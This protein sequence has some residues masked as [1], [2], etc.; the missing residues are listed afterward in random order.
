MK[1]ISP[2]AAPTTSSNLSPKY[3]M[4]KN[5]KFRKMGLIV[6]LL[7]RPKG[8]LINHK[9][10]ETYKNHRRSEMCVLLPEVKKS[11]LQETVRKVSYSS[12]V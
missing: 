3:L 8:L 7:Q 6:S 5:R 4:K 12:P 10:T 11:Y 1:A 2:T 9:T